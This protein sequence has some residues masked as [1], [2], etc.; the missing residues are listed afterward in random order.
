MKIIIKII[1]KKNWII[2]N[3]ETNWTQLKINCEK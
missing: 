3:N 1:I 2:V